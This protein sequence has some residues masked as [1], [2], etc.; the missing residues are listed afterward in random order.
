MNKK[1]IALLSAAGM[2]VGGSALLLTY[3]G[4]PANMGYCI[5]CFIRD[6]AG[7]VGLHNASAVQYMRPEI[8]GL[9]VG[10][11]AMALIGKE[12]RPS[13]GSS[14]ITRFLLGVFI[15]I[16]ALMFL[17]CPFRMILRLAGGDFN[18]IFGLIGFLLGIGAGIILLN[19][20]F[21]LNRSYRQNTSEGLIPSILSLMSLALLIVVPGTLYF[22]QSG[23]G[24]MHA[25]IIISLIA[26]LIVGAISQKSRLCT[27]GAVRDIFLFKDFTLMIGPFVIFLV[28]LIGNLIMG[29]FHPGFVISPDVPQ[30]VAH[31]DALWN[32]LGMVLVGFA[33]VLAGGCPFR[34]LVLAG[35]GNSDSAVCVL[36]MLLGAGLCHNLGLASSGA[37][38]TMAG[39]LAVIAGIATCVVI[40]IANLGTAKNKHI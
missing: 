34:Q 32:A 29:N 16:G 31:T 6:C 37:G 33:S 38:P 3:F 15:M 19:K 9:V 5:A 22:S 23:P 35:S 13:G 11:C 8:I 20:G 10:A 27:M 26:G 24:S 1:H 4:N 36:G 40:G 28:V 39:Q 21:S 17:G 25:P 2:L 18:A 7:S 14:P 12:F 30:P